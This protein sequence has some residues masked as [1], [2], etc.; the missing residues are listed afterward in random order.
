M[1]VPRRIERTTSPALASPPTLEALY[2]AHFDFVCRV[3]RRL[4]GRALL[5]EDVAQE[6]FLV[7]ARR[8]ES[9]EP[10]AQVT[11]WL[12]G[13][14]FNVVRSMRRRLLL[15][16]TYR[17]DESEGL[18]V[19]ADSFD[20]VELREAWQTMDEILESMA[21]RKREVF[22]IGELEERS[23]AEIARLVGAK[24]ATVWSRLHYA[25]R[26]FA[27]KLERRRQLEQAES[28]A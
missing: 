19:P 13:I 8:L 5:P 15:E 17:A 22:I 20:V 27:D 21:P 9:F 2:R 24:E 7:V 11:T 14:T 3:A 10:F 28:A 16:L 12:Y 26:E 1:P 25:R 23:C 4:A 18:D 6:V